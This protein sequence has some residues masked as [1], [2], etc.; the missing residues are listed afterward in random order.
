MKAWSKEKIITIFLCLIC[1]FCALYYLVCFMTDGKYIISIFANDPHD[2][3][4]DYFNSLN[5]A[6]FDPYVDMNSNYPALACLI[7]K[8]VFTIIPQELRDGNG[9]NLRNIQMAMIPFILYNTIIIWF[10][11]LLVRAKSTLSI[12]N[13]SILTF[14]ILI[15]APFV[16]TI[17]RGN[18]IF[19]SFALTLFFALFYDS[20]NKYIKELS[21]VALAI[22][23][24]IKIYPAIFGLLLVKRK[25]IKEALRLALYGIFA[26]VVPFFYYDG[27]KS[28]QIMIGALGYTSNLADEIGYG[29]NVSLFNICKTLGAIFNSN[30]ADGAISVLY[31]LVIGILVIS[32]FAIDS[33]WKE[34]LC[35]VML[36]VLL[37][38]TNYYY[39]MIFL[40]IPFVEYLNDV[41]ETSGTLD[42]KKIIYGI[43]YLVILV[44]WPLELIPMFSDKKFVVSYS[45]LLYYLA[46]I[47]IV[48]VLLSDALQRIIKNEKVVKF[49]NAVIGAG[50][51]GLTIA[52]FGLAR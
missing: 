36:L 11:N 46:L 45:M 50:S 38:K 52:A 41:N 13:K 44:P 8:F 43:I 49:M 51:V 20:D 31:V 16:F 18:L 30:I 37:P 28:L 24:A 39:V 23:A 12:T 6:K 15:S 9:F 4:M 25:K 29:I 48:N 40:L 5:N 47:W 35:L 32:F 22:A 42:I 14:L 27:I 7:Y 26:F 17:E 10:I 33:R 1:G 34:N 2:T 21:F 3:F 19:L